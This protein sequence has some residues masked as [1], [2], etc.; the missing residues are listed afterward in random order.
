MSE[1]T[2]T[3]PSLRHQNMKKVLVETEKVNKYCNI[4]QVDNITEL[5]ELI[6]ARTKLVN[7][8]ICISLRNANINTKPGWEMRTRNTNKE[9][10]INKQ[11]NVKHKKKNNRK[12]RLLKDNH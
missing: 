4:S 5:N 1:Q 3:L 8:K 12:K 7:N 2:I 11:K 10:A 6:Y 9:T